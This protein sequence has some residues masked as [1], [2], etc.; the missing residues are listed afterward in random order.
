MLAN[1]GFCCVSSPS[2]GISSHLFDGGLS[3]RDADQFIG[4]LVEFAICQMVGCK[5][6]YRAAWRRFSSDA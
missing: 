2:C 5:S 4:A 1:F 6:R 3:D